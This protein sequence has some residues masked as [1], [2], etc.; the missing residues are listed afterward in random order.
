MIHEAG[1]Q[2]ILVPRD[3]AML[4]ASMVIQRSVEYP[5]ANSYLCSSYIKKKTEPS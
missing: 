3:T 4:I 2:Q 5:I 1:M